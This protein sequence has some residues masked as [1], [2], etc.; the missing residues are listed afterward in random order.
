M[1]G[2]RTVVE[3]GRLTTI[4]YPALRA[5]LNARAQEIFA[6]NAPRRAELAAIEPFVKHFCVGLAQGRIE[7][8][9]SAGA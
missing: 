5:R 9:G 4:D 6:A 3:D 2:G 7:L 8:A 1:V